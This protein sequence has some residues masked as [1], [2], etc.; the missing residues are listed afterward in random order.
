M[1]VSTFWFTERDS[2]GVIGSTDRDLVRVDL[3]EHSSGGFEWD[4]EV[5]RQTGLE[6]LDDRSEFSE[7][8]LVYGAA[9][10][11]RIMVRPTISDRRK[12]ELH[13]RQP[14]NPGN[15][16]QLAITFNFDGTEAGGFSKAERRKVGALPA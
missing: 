8:P 2:D 12:I 14:W 9:A 15:Q 13:E 10:T 11:R 1:R 3:A 16:A 4:I 5:L 7:D 6:I